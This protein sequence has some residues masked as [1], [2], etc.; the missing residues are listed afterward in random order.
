MDTKVN[1]T[2]EEEIEAQ[3]AA[4]LDIIAGWEPDIVFVNNDNALKHVAVAYSQENPDS[5]LPFIFAGTN[6]DPSVYAPIGSLEHPAGSITGTLERI[7][8][9][10]A[11]AEARKVV[12]NATKIL[13]MSDASP[14]SVDAKREFLAWYALHGN[15]S[16]LQV[17][18]FVQTDDFNEWKKTV[19]GYQD[20]VDMIGFLGYQQV[21]DADRRV[22]PASE[23]ASWTAAN[24]VHPELDLIP[25]DARYGMLMGEG[26]SY[27]K[28]GMYGGIIGGQVL[29]GASPSQFPIIDPE[30]V[31][32]T[33]NRQRADDLN[34]TVPVGLLVRADEVY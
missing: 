1:H 32:L 26:I 17:V 18:D 19:E 31:E 33:F 21:R 23:V 8:F 13:L 30:V 12:P 28:T 20:S 22:L 9:G 25:S 3:G 15:D 2:T 6:I 24:S 7:P 34:T 29:K 14:S 27:L 11:F 10:A 16:P 4:A 5:G